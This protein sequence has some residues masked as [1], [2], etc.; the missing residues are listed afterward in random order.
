MQLVFFQV[1]IY[2]INTL[3]IN[4][5]DKIIIFVIEAFRSFYEF[6]QDVKLISDKFNP[7]KATL[8]TNLLTTKHVTSVF[9]ATVLTT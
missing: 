8:F 1:E 7:D 4:S 2:Y 5:I 3:K 6:T 9:H